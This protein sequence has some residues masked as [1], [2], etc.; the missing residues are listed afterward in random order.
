MTNQEI[1]N[2][3]LTHLRTQ[4]VMSYGSMGCAYRADNLSCAVGCL[5]P[6]ALYSRAY[7]GKGVGSL[8]ITYSDYDE[9]SSES[10][11]AEKLRKALEEGLQRPIDKPL[12]EFL[13]DL[14]SAHDGYMPSEPGK[15]MAEWETQMRRIAR[16]HNLTHPDSV[17]S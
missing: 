9:D 11:R 15:P 7:E 14:Q 1:F 4:G 17:S 10:V 13:R 3:V 6:D 8:A 5:I 12:V 2:K 16:A